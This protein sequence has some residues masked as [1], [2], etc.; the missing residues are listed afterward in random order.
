MMS[1]RGDVNDPSLPTRT[2]LC[3]CQES[4]EKE[5]RKV[6]MSYKALINPHANA[7]R[8]SRPTEGISTEL[9]IVALSRHISN[10][11]RHNTGIVIK[12]VKSRLF[13]KTK[14]Y[15]IVKDEVED[16]PLLTSG[17]RQLPP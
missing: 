11:R 9:K 6:E 10:G 14:R 12:N 5:L 3:T 7:I 13:P 16:K 15:S 8:S 4:R 17:I 1:G 2:G